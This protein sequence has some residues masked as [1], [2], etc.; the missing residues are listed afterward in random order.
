MKVSGSPNPSSRELVR[1]TRNQPDTPCAREGLEKDLSYISLMS[2]ATFVIKTGTETP[3]GRSG[4]RG[5]GVGGGGGGG[6]YLISNATHHHDFHVWM[7]S[8]MSLFNGSL[9]VQGKVTRQCP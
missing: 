5:V 8:V 6:L 3:G 9:I 2:C 7:G 1:R 4:G